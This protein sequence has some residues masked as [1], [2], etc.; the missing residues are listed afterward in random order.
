M[1]SEPYLK[2]FVRLGVLKIDQDLEDRQELTKKKSIE[3]N[4]F[5][6]L[7]QDQVFGLL[8]KSLR[9]HKQQYIKLGLNIYY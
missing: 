9:Y 7:I 4:D 1:E 6:Q 5:L 2:D 3:V 8:P